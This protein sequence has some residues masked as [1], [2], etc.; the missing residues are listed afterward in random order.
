MRV[1]VQN[2]WRALGYLFLIHTFLFYVFACLHAFKI[3]V[4]HLGIIRYSIS[5]WKRVL[6]PLLTSK[7]VFCSYPK[8]QKAETLLEDLEWVHWTG[9]HIILSSGKILDSFEIHIDV[10]NKRKIST[11]SRKRYILMCGSSNCFSKLKWNVPHLC[12]ERIRFLLVRSLRVKLLTIFHES[13][14]YNTEAFSYFDI[15]VPCE[16]LRGGEEECHIKKMYYR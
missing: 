16:L 3:V 14:V 1:E 13:K 15:E 4:V 2:I 11:S 7:A 12:S 8:S 5:S 10:Q 9:K 6:I